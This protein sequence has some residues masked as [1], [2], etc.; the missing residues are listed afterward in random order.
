MQKVGQKHKIPRVTQ[1]EMK[2][3]KHGQERTMILIRYL[4][5]SDLPCIITGGGGLRSWLLIFLV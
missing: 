4:Q 1:T 5:H 2:K 3:R